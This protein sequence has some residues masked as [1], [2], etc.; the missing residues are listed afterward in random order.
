LPSRALFDRLKFGKDTSQ[1]SGVKSVNNTIQLSPRGVAMGRKCPECGHQGRSVETQTV[2][3]MLAVSLHAIRPTHYY[4]CQTEE[5][6]VVYFAEDGEQR[7][8]EKELRDTVYQKHPHDE[9]VFI[10]YCFHHTPGSIREEW[11]QTGGSTVVATITAGTQTEQC[12]CDIRNP[13]GSCCLGNVR[14]FVHE[15]VL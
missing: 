2:K 4:F 11:R 8:S 6:A 13:Q 7:F 9:D 10:C 15:M 14:H 3:A 1:R 5:C 12:A